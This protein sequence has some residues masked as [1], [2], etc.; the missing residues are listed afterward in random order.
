MVDL[1]ELLRQLLQ[2]MA[3]EEKPDEQQAQ[4]IYDRISSVCGKED[5]D[6]E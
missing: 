6:D 5:E 4:R 2:E 3:E 1:D